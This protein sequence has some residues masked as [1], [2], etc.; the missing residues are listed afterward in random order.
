MSQTEAL[1]DDAQ[2]NEILRTA[3]RLAA[4]GEITFEEIV[5]AAKE[6][7]F[8]REELQNAEATYLKNSSEAGQRQEF[9]KMQKKELGAFAF[10]VGFLA[11]IVSLII[12]LDV[13]EW[14]W[15]LLSV[16]GIA[17]V[18][19]VVW[20]FFHLRGNSPK[21]EEAFENW[22]RRKHVWLRPERSKEMVESVITQEL[23]RYLPYIVEGSRRE[24]SIEKLRQKLGY[25]KP[26]ATAVFEAFIREH[27]E[28]EQN[29]VL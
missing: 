5:A 9:A 17:W 29:V 1:Y 11:L 3:V 18:G 24:N 16:V 15:P 4:P 23:Q 7:G 26:R 13:N 6:L 27:P 25:D 8:S 19:I 28:I 20:K 2:A 14:K 12:L 10:H 21:H 22:Q